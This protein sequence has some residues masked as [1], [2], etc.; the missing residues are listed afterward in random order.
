MRAFLGGLVGMLTGMI[1][2][3]VGVTAQTDTGST[4]SRQVSVILANQC[5]SCHGPEQKKG[6]L[7]LTRRSTALAGGESGSAIVP[8]VPDD[9]LVVDKIAEGEMPPKRPLAR[10]QVAAVRDWVKAGAVYESEPLASRR[11]GAGL[12]VASAD[13]TGFTASISRTGSGLG[14]DADRC[15]HPGRTQVQGPVAVLNGRPGHLDPPP[16]V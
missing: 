15:V 3:P 12:V 2:M 14:P 5:V 8:G 10:E 16:D 1:L 9:S 11:A 4:L 6:G 7:D 13:Q